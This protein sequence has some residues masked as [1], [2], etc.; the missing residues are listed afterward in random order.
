MEIIAKRNLESRNSLHG[1]STTSC[2]GIVFTYRFYYGGIRFKD[3]VTFRRISDLIDYL[4]DVCDYD[5]V[6]LRKI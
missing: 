1:V 3:T 4:L 2:D 5:S 6:T